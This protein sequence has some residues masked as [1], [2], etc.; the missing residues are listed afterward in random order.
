[1]SKVGGFFRSLLLWKH[2]R[3]TLQY[4]ILC[5][6]ILAFIF[7]VPRSCF[8]SESP[9]I[10]KTSSGGF[11]ESAAQDATDGEPATHNKKSN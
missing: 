3:G 7:F 8:I 4:D 11:A 6:L 2:E 9:E 10:P 1:M 5:A